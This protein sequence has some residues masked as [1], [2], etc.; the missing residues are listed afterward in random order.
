MPRPRA[1]GGVARALDPVERGDRVVAVA[2]HDH[3]IRVEGRAEE[4]ALGPATVHRRDDPGRRD[5]AGVEVHPQ[6]HPARGQGLVTSVLPRAHADHPHEVTIDQHVVGEVPEAVR[7][8]GDVRLVV[9]RIAERLLARGRDPPVRDVP[10]AQ[11][12]GE[13]R[14]E[15]ASLRV[16]RDGTD[17]AAGGAL[18]L[19]PGRLA[20]RVE[21]GKARPRVLVRLAHVHRHPHA[22]VREDRDRRPRRPRVCRARSSPWA[23]ARRR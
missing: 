1:R 2:G 6:D 20:V 18:G 21:Q 8:I 5:F 23:T 10:V 11:D 16:R 7:R 12:H 14:G 19:D 9:E 3:A 13:A 4:H 22:A 15:A 17:H